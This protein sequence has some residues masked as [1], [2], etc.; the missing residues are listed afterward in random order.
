MRIASSFFWSNWLGSE[1]K[2]CEA[3]STG[4]WDPREQVHELPAH[5][6][7][8]VARAA[9]IPLLVRLEARLHEGQARARRR[10]REREGHNGVEDHVAD[11]PR[12]AELPVRLD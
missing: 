4:S 5:H 7:P 12:V 11:D 8:A 10:G 3:G 6:L 1:A 9:E 2:A